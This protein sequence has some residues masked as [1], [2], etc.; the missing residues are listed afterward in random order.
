MTQLALLTAQQPSPPSGVPPLAQPLPEERPPLVIPQVQSQFT[1]P[2]A[3]LNSPAGAS[4]SLRTLFPDI[5]SA[6]IT[7]VITHDLKAAD[8]YKLDTRVKDSE[9]TYSLSATGS[10]EM[11]VSRHKAYKNL[12]SI[13]FPLHNYFA[14]LAAHF[15]ARSAATVYFY[16]Y[17]THL[18]TLATEYEWAAVLEYHTLF[19]NRRRGDMLAGSYD[20][21]A[22]S[23]IGLLSSHVYPH[24]K[25]INVTPKP[26]KAPRPPST[27]TDPCRNF[28]AGKCGT[29][30]A[31]NRP[32][33]CSSPGCGKD[34]PL[35]QHK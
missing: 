19:F 17:L 18:T 32:H 3:P 10:F 13:V 34:H 26:P 12:N 22:C 24:R 30:C 8:L 21:W 33:V 16:R 15:P 20:G 11:N 25:Q 1:A 9:P 31:W 14:I 35:T 27:S 29:P 4:H 7:S 23:D 5:E 28:N 2:L 6:C